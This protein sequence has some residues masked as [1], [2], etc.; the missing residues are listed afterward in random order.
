MSSDYVKYK[1]NIWKF[2]IINF[3]GSFELISAV[4]VLFLLANNLSMTQVMILQ[5]YFTL[6]TLLLEVPSGVAADFFGLK[7]TLIISWILSALGFFIYGMSYSLWSFVIAETIIAL[8]WAMFSGTDSTLIYDSLKQIGEEKRHKKA[9]GMTSF[10]GHISVGLSSLLGGYLASLFGFRFLFFMASLIMGISTFLLFTLKEPRHYEKMKQ[11]NYFK[12]LKEGLDF[13][14]RKKKIR[15][16][17][18]FNAI[19][20]GTTY[21]LFF[22]L[23]PYLK[24]NGFSLTFVGMG[25]FGYFFFNSIGYLLSDR[26]TKLEQNDDRTLKICGMFIAILFLILGI[27]NVYIGLIAISIMMFFSALRDVLVDYKINKETQSTHRATI[28]SIKN[29]GRSLFYSIFAPIIGYLSDIY[30][31]KATFLMIGFGLFLFSI[32]SFFM[33]KKR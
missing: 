6:M 13:S 27:F 2:H 1:S 25:I 28:L 32:F 9:M 31:L 3:L 23:Q 5:A 14:F 10:V 7:N 8:S 12:H 24:N 26:L 17:M 33:F 4:F 16:L 20:G 21:I 30:T 18:I 19:L 11:S 29:M 15:D 22:L